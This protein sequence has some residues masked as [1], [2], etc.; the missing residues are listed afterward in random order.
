MRKW[1]ERLEDNRR[2]GR[3][4]TKTGRGRKAETQKANIKRP[5]VVLRYKSHTTDPVFIYNRT[6]YIYMFLLYIFLIYMSIHFNLFSPC[7]SNLFACLF[8]WFILQYLFVHA[9]MFTFRVSYRQ[10]YFLLRETLAVCIVMFLSHANSLYNSASVRT[11]E[12][13]WLGRSEE[14]TVAH[15]LVLYQD[16]IY[17]LFNDAGSNSDCIRQTEMVSK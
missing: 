2:K 3:A 17:C 11:A 1:I 13:H 9:S 4:A 6:I 10:F 5:S 7:C 15:I 14:W 12:G 16:C 8:V